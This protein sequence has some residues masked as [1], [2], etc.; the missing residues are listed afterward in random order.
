MCGFLGL[1]GKSNTPENLFINALNQ[2]NHR[3]PDESTI[4]TDVNLKLGFKRLKILDL[5]KN[6]RQPMSSNDKSTTIIF[7]GEIYNYIRIKDILIKSG[8]KFN[9]NSDT[10]V[11][12]NY[13]IFLER[14]IDKLVKNCN[15]MFSFAIVDRF[16]KKIYF[17]RDRLGV[18]PLYYFQDNNRI[19]FSSEIKSIKYLIK[20]TSISKKAISAYLSL[21][22]V[23][24]W[25]SIFREIKS[26]NP[27]EYAV[28][29]FDK[30][31]LVFKKYWFPRPKK[32]NNDY[33]LTDWK[34]LIKKELLDATKI[35]LNSDVPVGLL[36][37]GGI[38]SGLVAAAVSKIGFKDLNAHTISFKDSDR[39]ESYLAKKT[40]N[41]LG[42]KLKIHDIDQIT[43]SD[44]KSS[45]QHFDQPF[46]DP[47]LIVT[48][49][50]C[51]K[52]FQNSTTVVLTG[53]GGDESFC[54]YREYLK[55]AKYNFFNKLPDILLNNLGKVLSRIP[56][57]KI[58]II[59][60][61]LKLN[62]IS[63]VMWTH[64]YPFDDYLSKLFENKF[65]IDNKFNFNEA[66]QFLKYNKKYDNLT[67][68]Q[69]T[70]LNCYLPS[71]VLKKT[72]MMSMKNSIELRSPFLDYRLVELGLSVPKEY[73]IQNNKTKYIL[74][75]IAKDWLPEEISKSKKKGFGVPLDQLFLTNDNYSQEVIDQILKLNDYN[76]FDK[77]KLNIYLQKKDFSSSNL[78]SIYKLYCLSIFLEKK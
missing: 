42:L 68:S 73:K 49:L 75:E 1:A 59:S 71:N 9:G 2:I 55:L 78:R 26:I 34:E 19:I 35:R 8:V 7:N 69:I 54:G 16:K 64:I 15:G 17:V 47:S 33:N 21:G 65:K 27:G 4:F 28:W 24:P 46:A 32:L 48:D 22:F 56:N 61:R 14:D 37:S 3:G 18:K 72:D 43:L 52:V 57:Q 10:E 45:I 6:G 74:R 30:K 40:A 36:L 70:D 53:D 63:R 20:D 11:L 50:I 25:L 38:D 62:K 31:T 67:V 66:E 76:F 29:D 5:S 41:H 39:D 23:P 12:L 60:N 44:I 13:Y 77:N 51:R 58:K